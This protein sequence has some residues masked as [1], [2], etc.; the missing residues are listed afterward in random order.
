MTEGWQINTAPWVLATAAA[1]LAV[2]VWFFLRS[3]KREG[4]DGWHVALHV[5]RLLIAAAKILIVKPK[6][7]IIYQSFRVLSPRC[8]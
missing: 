2:S 6:D 5:L 4:H 1:F 7:P 8:P 3:L